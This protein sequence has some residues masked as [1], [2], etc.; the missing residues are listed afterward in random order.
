MPLTGH[1]SSSFT[2]CNGASSTAMLQF[3][4]LHLVWLKSSQTGPPV[5]LLIVFCA[6]SSTNKWLLLERPLCQNKKSWAKSAIKF[7]NHIFLAWWI[8]KSQ[9]RTSALLLPCRLFFSFFFKGTGGS[10]VCRQSFHSML[11]FKLAPVW[12][13]PPLLCLLSCC[14]THEVETPHIF[15]QRESDVKPRP[16]PVIQK[17][18]SKRRRC[19]SE[20]GCPTAAPSVLCSPT[21]ARRSS[22]SSLSPRPRGTVADH[23]R[24]PDCS[25][26][27]R[28]NV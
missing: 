1:I 16:M 28:V 26:Y 22:W 5:R 25:N 13:I 23:G 24:L 10:S 11:F 20:G 17:T 12:T 6:I 15:W 3:E 9:P 4:L 8:K 18:T 7:Q 2:T 27:C 14:P 21:T 19:S